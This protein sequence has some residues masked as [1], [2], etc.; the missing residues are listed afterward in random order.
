MEDEHL[1]SFHSDLRWDRHIPVNPCAF[2]FNK[3]APVPSMERVSEAKELMEE[4]PW[5]W[6]CKAWKGQG[7]AFHL[8]S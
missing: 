3:I 5:A 7:R 2:Q 8:E 6:R 1:W 4:T